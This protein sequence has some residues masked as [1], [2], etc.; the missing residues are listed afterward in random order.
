MNR[1]TTRPTTTTT[2]TTTTTTTTTTDSEKTTSNTGRNTTTTTM[3]GGGIGGGGSSSRRENV[4]LES[5]KINPNS[6]QRYNPQARRQRSRRRTRRL[7]QKATD[8][9]EKQ[10]GG[11]GG[12]DSPL[13]QF[14]GIDDVLVSKTRRVTTTTKAAAMAHGTSSG[15]KPANGKKSGVRISRSS[16]GG[17]ND[18][19]SDDAYFFYGDQNDYDNYL[20]DGEEWTSDVD[21]DDDGDDDTDDVPRPGAMRAG[22]EGHRQ[23]TKG[24]LSMHPGSFDGGSSDDD[25]V[26][27]SVFAN[28][29]DVEHGRQR[30]Q[31]QD[32][33]KQT[34]IISKFNQKRVAMIAIGILVAVVIAVVVAIVLTK[35]D[36]TNNNTNQSEHSAE[37]LLLKLELQ[38]KLAYLSSPSSDPEVVFNDPN[39]PQSM[40]IQ[41]LIHK[42]TTL[43]NTNVTED[44]V[45][46]FDGNE[47]DRERRL[48]TRYS[49]AVLYYATMVKDPTKPRPN[50][51][52]SPTLHECNW[53]RAISSATTT[54]P[55]PS[56][57]V[58]DS[59]SQIVEINLGTIEFSTVEGRRVF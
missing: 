1:P 10:S 21:D 31:Q 40:A 32:S 50:D 37:N 11:K 3:V 46:N 13:K 16:G 58:C 41:W 5:L 6:Q 39:S 52:L 19:D 59:S 36:G 33:D 4:G 29:A 53:T 35:D 20:S 43:F 2:A 14:D 24:R 45:F 8:K 25:S 7:L 12:H 26:L 34:T 28:D 49:L 48:V 47:E 57:I 17:G 15:K 23:L 54:N 42:D 22:P 51:F 18:D 27:V 56:I 30:Q 44:N 55:P 38:S 9:E